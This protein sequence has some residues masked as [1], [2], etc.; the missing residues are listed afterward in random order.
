MN[1]IRKLI[2]KIT[3]IIYSNIF[4]ALINEYAKLVKKNIIISKGYDNLSTII[5]PN[6]GWKHKSVSKW[7]EFSLSFRQKYAIKRPLEELCRIREKF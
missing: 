7:S 3:R 4:T 6:F 1:Q 2:K 5:R